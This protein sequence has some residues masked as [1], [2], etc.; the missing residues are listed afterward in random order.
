MDG[1]RNTAMLK[2][3]YYCL[4]INLKKTKIGHKIRRLQREQISY[5]TTN[6]RNNNIQKILGVLALFSVRASRC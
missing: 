4:A 6:S 5:Q 3:Y 1:Y 2:S